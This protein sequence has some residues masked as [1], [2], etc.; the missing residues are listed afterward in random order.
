MAELKFF[1]PSVLAPPAPVARETKTFTTQGHEIT[2][3]MEINLGGDVTEAIKAEQTSLLS[4][5][6]EGGAKEH[7]ICRPG[8][9]PVVFSWA[10]AFSIARLMRASV[11]PDGAP[12]GWHLWTV[13]QWAL[14]AQS[15]HATFQAIVAWLNETENRL[16]PEET[17]G[18]NVSGADGDNV[19]TTP[20]APPDST[21]T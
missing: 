1:D 17:P 2:L 12:E 3:C 7:S 15:D 13:A 19:S 4:L 16:A 18:G 6:G 8:S 21:P 11:V 10:L 20:S 5:Y 9:V 14:L